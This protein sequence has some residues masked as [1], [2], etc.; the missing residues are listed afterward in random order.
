MFTGSLIPSLL[1]GVYLWG[2]VVPR[3]ERYMIDKFGASYQNK[4]YGYVCLRARKSVFRFYP[5]AM[6]EEK[7]RIYA[8]MMMYGFGRSSKYHAENRENRNAGLQ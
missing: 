1:L 4:E 6:H 7:W 3:E 2:V 5:F 8:S